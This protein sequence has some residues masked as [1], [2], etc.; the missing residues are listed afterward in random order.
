MDEINRIPSAEDVAFV[1]AVF[2]GLAEALVR[3][4]RP[5]PGTVGRARGI[6]DR[7]LSSAMSLERQGFGSDDADSDS[8]NIGTDEA[9]E[10]LGV[11]RRTIQRN[12]E[13]LGGQ[14][15]S[16]AWVFDRDELGA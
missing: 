5:M 15:I 4:G 13:S 2:D 11:T 14:R 1:A 9:A 3:F 6:L 16:G 10:L 7:V 8:G 12:A